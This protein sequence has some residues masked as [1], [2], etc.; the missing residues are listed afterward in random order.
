VR[1]C[2]FCTFPNA[3]FT[4]FGAGVSTDLV[5][6][7]LQTMARRMETGRKVSALYVGGATANLTPPSTLDEL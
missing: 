2:G 5:I 6:A 3:Q 1:G 7:E 4:A